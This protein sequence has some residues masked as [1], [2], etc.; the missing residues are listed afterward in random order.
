[1]RVE[2]KQSFIKDLERLRDRWLRERVGETI[3]QLEGAAS[4]QEIEGVK[5]LRGGE[6]YYRI[7]IGDYRLGLF[8]AEDR[9]VL[10]RFLHRK[11]M[12][13]YFP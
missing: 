6:G 10:I 1:M 4:L 3:E 5:K 7:R 12:Y 2:F 13:R 8:W 9:V 11:D